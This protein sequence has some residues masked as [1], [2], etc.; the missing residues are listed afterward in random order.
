MNIIFLDVD[1]VL[2]STNHLMELYKKYKKPF[3]GFDTPFDPNC[4]KNLNELVTQT[5]SK[6]VISSTWR[7]STKGMKILLENLEKY[8]LDKSIIGCTPIFNTNVTSGSEIKTYLSQFKEH[9]SKLNFIIL[10]DESDMDELLPH[11]IKTDENF[12]L[13]CEN[14]KA[15]I[16]K[17]NKKRI[18]ETDDFER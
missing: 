6:L 10:D 9:Q 4:L 11:L 17:L 1:G 3:C 14:V 2:N 12:G 7:K 15:A 5:N 16:K 18:K 13:T 8:E